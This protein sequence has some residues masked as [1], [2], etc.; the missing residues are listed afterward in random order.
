MRSAELTDAPGAEGTEA[1]SHDTRVIP[2]DVTNDETGI[3]RA[4]DQPDRA[5][6]TQHERIGDVADRRAVRVFG[7]PDR[8]HELV[9]G[10]CHAD[11]DRLLFAPVQEFPDPGAEGEELPVVGLARLGVGIGTVGH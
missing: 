8:E 5:V 6:V 2:V 3:D 11:R 9:L 7:S 10:G 4:I 1:Q